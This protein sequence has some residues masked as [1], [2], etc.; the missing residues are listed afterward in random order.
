M[1]RNHHQSP[2]ASGS[3]QYLTV[4]EACEL[5]R[6]CRRTLARWVAEDRFVSVR[7]VAAGSGKRLVCR[8]SFLRFLG[9]DGA[10]SMKVSNRH[11][12]EGGH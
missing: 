7:P 8:E 10:A 4:R 9:V 12:E 1:A 11:D 2:K 6:C 5:A 3:P